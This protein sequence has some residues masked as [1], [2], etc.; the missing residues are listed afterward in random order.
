VSIGSRTIFSLGFGTAFLIG[1]F[2]FAAPLFFEAPHSVPEI[3]RGSCVNATFA[4]S[5]YAEAKIEYTAFFGSLAGFGFVLAAWSY[6]Q[7]NPREDSRPRRED[8]ALKPVSSP[9]VWSE[10]MRCGG[11]LETEAERETGICRGCMVLPS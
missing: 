3:C 10:C 2:I 7:E 4:S 11:P 9:A 6:R 1:G 5:Q 8:F